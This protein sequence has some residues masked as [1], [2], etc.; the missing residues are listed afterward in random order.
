LSQG[1]ALEVAKPKHEMGTAHALKAQA[2]QVP[3]HEDALD[4]TSK[5]HTDWDFGELPELMQITQGQQTLVGFPALID[6]GDSVRLQVFDEPDVAQAQHLK[7]LNRLFVLQLKEPIKYLQKNMNDLAKMNL[8]YLQLFPK[9]SATQ[10][11][12]QVLDVAVERAFLMKPLPRQQSDFQ[13]RL[14]EGRNRFQ[15]I[16]QEVAKAVLGIL[17][18]AQT[19]KRKLK[20]SRLPKETEQDVNEQLERLLTHDFVRQVPQL[21]WP[22]LPR[23]LKAIQLRLEKYRAD[24]KRDET[25]LSEIKPWEQKFWRF[26][27]QRKGQ[28][29]RASSDFRW[30]LEE[31]RV[32][33]FAQELRTPQPVSLK[34]LE[35]AWLLLNQ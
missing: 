27:Q 15:L 35:K 7:G 29:D 18:E 3:A 14:Q 16:S 13:L 20:D 11:F 28:H 1:V 6:Q 22:H 31:M 9:A 10:L 4:Q 19:A 8:I 30:M 25:K 32:S 34:R 21:Q 23:Y 33:S 24:P 2:V 5:A 17:N 12:Q 26:M